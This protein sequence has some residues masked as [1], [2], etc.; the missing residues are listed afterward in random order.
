MTPDEM[1]R[2]A[3]WLTTYSRL[4]SDSEPD[5]LARLLREEAEA[6][7][8][9]PKPADSLRRDGEVW[10]TA[11]GK[12]RWSHAAGKWLVIPPPPQGREG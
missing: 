12:F 10:N 6:K 7:E 5:D 11:W 2:A 8:S 4:S 3:Q 1:R 9:E